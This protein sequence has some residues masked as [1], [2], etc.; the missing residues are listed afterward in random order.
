MGLLRTGLWAGAIILLLPSEPA[1][2]RELLANA[3]EKIEW[4]MTFCDRRPQTCE[5]A[6]YA[7]E[8]FL[9]KARFGAEAAVT[10]VRQHMSKSSEDRRHDEVATGV[11]GRGTLRQSD[12]ELAWS[13]D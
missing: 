10:L 13:A 6:G 7:W 1:K 4:A 12:L 3:S 5:K 8:Q 9:I 11:S 2:Q